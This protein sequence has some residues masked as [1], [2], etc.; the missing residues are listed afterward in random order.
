MK[1]TDFPSIHYS[2]IPPF[3]SSRFISLIKINFNLRF[4]NLAHFY[5]SNAASKEICEEVNAYQLADIS[6]IA[7]LVAGGVHESPV[8]YADVVTTTTHKSLRGPRGAIIMCKKEDRLHDLYHSK[9]VFRSGKKKNLADLIDSAVFPGLQG[10][11]HDH[12]NA[13]K[14]VA[15]GEVLKPEF[16]EYAA[17]VVKNAKALAD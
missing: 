4:Y 9:A 10:G 8:P 16:K 5:L 13:A 14:A 6:H 1:K 15:F 2:S 3:H 17:Q 11:P 7:G 12:I